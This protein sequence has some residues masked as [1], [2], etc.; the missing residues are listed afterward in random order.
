M[1]AGADFSSCGKYRYA[2]WRIWD[3]SKKV[4]MCIGLNPS[5][6]NG[7]KDDPTIRLLTAH[8]TDLGYGGFRM[9]NLYALVSPK[10]Q[11]LF[12]SPDPLGRND[13]WLAIQAHLSQEIIFCWGSFKGIEIRVKKMKAMFP[14]ALCFGKAKNG[15][16]L[17]PMAMMYAGVK[18]GEA[19]LSRYA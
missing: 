16:P 7:T 14:D 3:D 11:A 18:R 19:K 5:T 17:H 8:L 4:A 9:V 6:A 2:L 15:A 12:D 10:P 13:D 1:K